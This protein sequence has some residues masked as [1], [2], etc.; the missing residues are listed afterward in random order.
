[1][2]KLF[3]PSTQTL[4][5]QIMRGQFQSVK[6]SKIARQNINLIQTYRPKPCPSRGLGCNE[7]VAI[8]FDQ[9]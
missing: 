2:L 6:L 9:G 3:A 8:G 1:M 5:S 7:I 4:R